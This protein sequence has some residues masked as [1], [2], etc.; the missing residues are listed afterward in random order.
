MFAYDQAFALPRKLKIGFSAS[1]AD[2]HVAAFQDLGFAAVKRRGRPGFKVYGGGGLGNQS[3]AGVPL[4]DFLP[5][6]EAPRAALAMASLF[7]DHGDRENRNTARIRFILRRLGP[8]SFVELF[9]DYLARTAPV[10]AAAPPAP[11]DLG[12]AVEALKAGR[13]PAPAD[14]DYRDW[15]EY[16]VTPTAFG[17]EVVSVRLFVP[18]GNLPPAGLA[19]VAIDPA[20]AVCMDLGAST[21][22]F[23]DV[24]LRAG[25]AKVYA[26]DVGFGQLDWRIREILASPS[27]SAP[28]RA[29]S[30]RPCLTPRPRS[31]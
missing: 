25:A 10:A 31:P 11:Y 5:A 24:L 18:Y 28:T 8:E 26:I 16:A 19:A 12:K 22:G 27:W 29:R 13:E 9:K 17:G 20:G 14:A 4:L 21:G 2:E 1:P 30:S 7:S 6:A 3:S 23:T 15:L